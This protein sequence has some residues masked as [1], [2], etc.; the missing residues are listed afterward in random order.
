MRVELLGPVQV[1][2]DGSPR[3][4]AGKRE[5]ALVA[6]LALSPGET[7]AAGDRGRRAVGSPRARPT[8]T[9]R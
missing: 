3:T 6:L 4:P 1:L 2:V 8:V 9:G 7:V 5:R